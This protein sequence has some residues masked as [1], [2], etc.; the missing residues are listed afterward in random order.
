[1]QQFRILAREILD[2]ARWYAS[3]D[4][5][6]VLNYILDI[7]RERRGVR[8]NEEEVPVDVETEESFG[9]LV[10]GENNPSDYAR[11]D[12]GGDIGGFEGGEKG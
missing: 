1:M 2:Q 4:A 3:R 12:E 11:Y 9:G 7:R 8:D 6:V 10:A 5:P